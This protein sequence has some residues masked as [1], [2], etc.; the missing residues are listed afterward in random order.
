[1]T[2]AGGCRERPVLARALGF[3]FRARL[4]KRFLLYK[5]ISASVSA[6]RPRGTT[7]KVIL[8]VEVVFILLVQMQFIMLQL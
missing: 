2:L 8:V 3:D 1:V 7:L 4:A 5:K 6:L